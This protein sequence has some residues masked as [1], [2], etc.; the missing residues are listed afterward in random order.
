MDSSEKTNISIIEVYAHVSMFRSRENTQ[1]TLVAATI[2]IFPCKSFVASTLQRALLFNFNA[3]NCSNFPVSLFQRLTFR[4]IL[5]IIFVSSLFFKSR[6][7]IS[8][9]THENIACNFHRFCN[10]RDKTDVQS[11]QINANNGKWIFENERL[12][13]FSKKT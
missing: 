2:I 7:H 6:R 11:L 1:L 8:A 9:H 4:G 13:R 12:E 3:S 5:R 10:D